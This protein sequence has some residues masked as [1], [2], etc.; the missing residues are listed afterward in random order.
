MYAAVACAEAGVFKRVVEGVF[1]FFC[2][3]EYEWSDA[4]VVVCVVL[5][6]CDCASD[7]DDYACGCFADFYG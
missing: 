2:Y 3:V 7:G 1:V 4:C 5:A 6:P